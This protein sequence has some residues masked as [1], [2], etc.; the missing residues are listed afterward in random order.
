MK[1]L[2]YSAICLVLLIVLGL[3]AGPIVSLAWDPSPDADVNKY[4]LYWGPSSGVYNG[5]KDLGN[6][7]NT[8]FDQLQPATRYFF[9]VTAF[10]E[11]G[12][13]SDPSNELDYLTPGGKPRKPGPSRFN[14]P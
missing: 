2:A 4:R 9:V 12:A 7:T 14:L 1:K 13:E 8:I 5:S 10:N 11:A 3:Q 6:V